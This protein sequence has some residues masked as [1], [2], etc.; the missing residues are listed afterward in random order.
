[1]KNFFYFANPSGIN[2]EDNGNLNVWDNGVIGNFWH[3]YVG[4]DGNGNG[5]GDTPY[6]VSG[7]SNSKDNFPLM[8][9][10]FELIISKIFIHKNIERLNIYH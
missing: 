5:I 9:W 3:D 10:L 1:M 6:N 4:T 8:E 7:S 2:A